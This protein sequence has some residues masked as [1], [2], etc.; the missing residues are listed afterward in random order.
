MNAFDIPVGAIRDVHG[1]EVHYDYTVWTSASDLKNIRW[2]YRTYNDQS[3]RS[4]DVRTAL[5]AAGDQVK[6]IE[7]DSEQPMDDV[8]TKFM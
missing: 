2:A 8:S 4:V 1:N 5:S 7:M 6:L 3:M